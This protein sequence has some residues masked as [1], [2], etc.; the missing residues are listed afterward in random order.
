[1]DLKAPLAKYREVV[2]VPVSRDEVRR[3]ID[4]ILEAGVDHEFRTTCVKP[5]LATRDLLEMGR[6][7]VGAKRYRLQ[8]FV[9][10]GVLNAGFGDTAVS[11]CEKE[12]QTAAR[13]ITQATNIDCRV[14][15][16]G[17]IRGR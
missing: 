10:H 6:E 14:R 3:S 7:I 11:F 2:G 12:L 17:E 1:M 15:I 8:A 9:N 5:L 13:R 16:P 4:A